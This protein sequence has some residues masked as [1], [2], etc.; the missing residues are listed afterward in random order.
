MGMVL[1]QRLGLAPDWVS[2]CLLGLLC[3][4]ASSSQ[5]PG[6]SPPWVGM[7]S[8]E[9]LGREMGRVVGVGVLGHGQCG[10]LEALIPRDMTDG[11]C[12]MGAA[13]EGGVEEKSP[14]R[15]E[16]GSLSVIHPSALS[17]AHCVTATQEPHLSSVPQ[18]P[19]LEGSLSTQRDCSQWEPGPKVIH[20]EDQRLDRQWPGQPAGVKGQSRVPLTLWQVA[21]VRGGTGPPSLPEIIIV[22]R[23]G[24]IIPLLF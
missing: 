7:H 23:H 18:P 1:Y 3:E 22:L 5:V 16:T 15:T 12:L 14:D 6:T 13:A 19:G 10:V 20:T 8:R 9:R 24:L 11:H 4:A 21:G 17:A 2:E